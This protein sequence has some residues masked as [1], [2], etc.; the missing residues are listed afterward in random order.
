MK[1]FEVKSFLSIYSLLP[2]LTKAIDKLIMTRALCSYPQEDVIS[3][4]EKI[5]KLSQYKINLINLKLLTDKTL[6]KM[7][8]EASSLIICRFIDE[9]S[10]NDCIF[11]S[12]M[13]RRSYFRK[14]GS[15][16]T[17]FK[18]TFSR[19]LDES[20][21]SIQKAVKDEFWNDVFH[22]IALFNAKGKD[23]S[24]CKDSLCSIILGRMRKFV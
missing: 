20:R 8:E 24:P 3:H 21:P 6:V 7:P 19:I 17:T 12:G 16:L 1:N 23:V 9:M 2:S 13:S 14:F 5:A 15:A 18:Q 11:L 4:A 10:L 22:S